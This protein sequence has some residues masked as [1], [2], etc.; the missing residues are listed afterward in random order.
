MINSTLSH[1]DHAKGTSE[2]PW[3]REDVENGTLARHSA[4]KKRDEKERSDRFDAGL[5][6]E[7]SMKRIAESGTT[8]EKAKAF[9][10][11]QKNQ[12]SNPVETETSFGDAMASNDNKTQVSAIQTKLDKLKKGK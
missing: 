11:M 10:Y 3:T 5:S 6:E 2:N 9:D 7:G 12:P 4:E 1:Q 8:A